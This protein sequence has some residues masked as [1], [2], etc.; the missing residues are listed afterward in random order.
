[1]LPTRTRTLWQLVAVRG[2]SSTSAG[3]WLGTIKVSESK[4]TAFPNDVLKYRLCLA[5]LHSII[6]GVFIHK[7]LYSPLVVTAAAAPS[8][9]Q[10]QP[11]IAKD[12]WELDRRM[13]SLEGGSFAVVDWIAMAR[14]SSLTDRFC[15]ADWIFAA[16]EGRWRRKQGDGRGG[17]WG[18]GLCHGVLVGKG[19]DG[20][21][22][23]RG[24]GLRLAALFFLEYAGRGRIVVLSKKKGRWPYGVADAQALRQ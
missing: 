3:V 16:R 22:G 5:P 18:E 17:R 12:Q 7:R 8:V 23:W 15:L 13:T 1:M 2:S 14:P 9:P 10:R 11:I 24:E 20:R 19:G 6:C 21:G 4:Y